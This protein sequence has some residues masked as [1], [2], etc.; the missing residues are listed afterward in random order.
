MSSPQRLQRPRGILSLPP[1]I[2]HHIFGCFDY[3]LD[4]YPSTAAWDIWKEEPTLDGRDQEERDRRQTIKNTRLVC[5]LFDELASPLLYVW[6]EVGI[7]RKSLDFIEHLATRP[8]LA[9][10]LRHLSLLLEYCPGEFA[11][12]LRRFSAI[13][14]FYV[15]QERDSLRGHCMWKMAQLLLREHILKAWDVYFEPSSENAPPDHLKYQQCLL[16]GHKEYQERHREQFHLIIQGTF[17]QRLAAALTHMPHCESLL[18]SEGHWR[19]TIY[20]PSPARQLGE[21]SWLRQYMDTP[22]L[23]ERIE[24]LGAELVPATI[25][26]DLPVALHKAGVNVRKLH[27]NCFPINNGFHLLHPSSEGSRKSGSWA[28]LSAACRGLE[29]FSFMPHTRHTIGYPK[30]DPL[31]PQN[32]EAINKFL[33]VILSGQC[34]RSV[35]FDLSSRG[36]G[37]PE[38]DDSNSFGRALSPATWFGLKF[39]R[40]SYLTFNQQ[41]LEKLCTSLPD[42]LELLCMNC[43]YLESGVWSKALDIL[44]D[45]LLVRCMQQRCKVEFYYL[46]GGGLSSD[47]VLP[48]VEAEEET[49][50][51]WKKMWKFCDEKEITDQ[52]VEKYVSGAGVSENPLNGDMRQILD[53]GPVSCTPALV[54]I[55]E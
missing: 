20:N 43:I 25:L 23:W 19:S 50:E 52:L 39:L 1:E 21:M 38:R 10:G 12:D 48:I 36:Y 14:R 49:R 11:T 26:V 31:T 9:K 15:E 5:R 24:D 35:D 13:P 51:S 55:G 32:R 28:D 54:L 22:L 30:T 7:S 29:E 42:D 33:S 44:R 3:P 47:D 27:M 18:M 41:A 8:F 17:I 16:E 6:L 46:D 53:K 34:L 4:F 2:L 40:V 37:S 45:K